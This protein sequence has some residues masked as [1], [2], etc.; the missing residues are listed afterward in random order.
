MTINTIK[1]TILE[2]FEVLVIIDRLEDS[3]WEV[4]DKY[5]GQESIKFL[6]NSL[7]PRI[8]EALKFGITQARG[9]KIVFVMADNCDQISDINI[10]SKLID[11]NKDLVSAS[12][13]TSKSKILDA[14]FVKSKL[15]YLAGAS[16]C[17]F[18]D[19][20][21]NDVTNT[22]KMYKAEFLKSVQVNSSF[23]FT[24]GLELLGLAHKSKLAII[25]IPTVWKER[26]SGNSKFKLLKWLPAYLFWYLKLFLI[27]VGGKIRI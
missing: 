8:A 25:E 12:R 27:L 10:M 26:K 4:Q 24:I 6:H 14:P 21:T 3:T 7:P 22:F 16:L 2:D 18:F 11:Q 15:S 9:E 19:L 1:S 13:Y 23:G 5:K 17:L 20:G